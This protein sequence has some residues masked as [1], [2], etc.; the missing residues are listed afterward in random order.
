MMRKMFW[1]ERKLACDSNQHHI[2]TTEWP[3]TAA[4]Q[5]QKMKNINTERQNILRPFAFIRPEKQELAQRVTISES[6]GVW[7][8]VDPYF[9][10]NVMRIPM[11]FSSFSGHRAGDVMNEEQ[12][13]CVMLLTRM[14]RM[15]ANGRIKFLI[16]LALSWIGWDY[17]V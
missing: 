7:S 9:L 11:R 13:E 16:W 1:S 6:L 8:R 3:A 12:F 14:G 15:N 2:T 10:P 17:G 4:A 5:Q